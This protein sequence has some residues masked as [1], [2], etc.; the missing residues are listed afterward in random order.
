MVADKPNWE[1]MLPSDD[2]GWRAWLRRANRHGLAGLIYWEWRQSPPQLV[3]DFILAELKQSYLATLARNTILLNELQRI[4][5]IIGAQDIKVVLLKGAVFARTLYEDIGMRPMSDLDILLPEEKI[6]N[7]VAL[8]LAN[9][10]EEPVLLQREMMKKEV[11]HDIHLRQV[12]PPHVDVEVHW[13]LAAGQGYRQKVE[14]NWFWQETIPLEGEPIG[15]FT[16]SPTANLLYLCAHLAFQHGLGSAGLLWYVDI[17][18]FL[19]IYGSY[20]NWDG[21]IERAAMMQWSAAVYYTL[22]ALVEKFGIILPNGVCEKLSGQ[23]TA[24]EERHIQKKMI[25]RT[26]SAAL[27]FSALEQLTWR[28]RIKDI[29]SRLFPS[30]AF[31]R[32]RFGFQSNWA[33]LLG[34]PLRWIELTGKFWDFLAQKYSGKKRIPS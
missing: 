26:G 22:Q 3:P 34:Y 5:Q 17:A 6:K 15:V 2:P 33:A 10:Y 4:L 28:G 11:A 12:D 20:I 13:R 7:G 30:L 14:M 1:E 24:E 21:L 23:I 8:L 19:E 27:A 32:A 18:R 29:F 25:P 31:M 16:L 9:G